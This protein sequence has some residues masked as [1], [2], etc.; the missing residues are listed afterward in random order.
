MTTNDDDRLYIYLKSPSGLFYFFG[1]QG[2]VLNVTS[3]NQRFMKPLN[4]MKDKDRIV[5]ISKQLS[6]EIQGVTE[7]TANKFIQRARA[8]W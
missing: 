7:G 2:E 6:F 5:D 8:A 3:D 4:E 1:L